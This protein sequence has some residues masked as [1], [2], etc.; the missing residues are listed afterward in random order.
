M[1]GLKTLGCKEQMLQTR[2]GTNLMGD[3]S[4]GA[5]TQ[6]CKKLIGAKTKKSKEGANSG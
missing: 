1:F 6:R 4:K 3:N 5:K 2:E